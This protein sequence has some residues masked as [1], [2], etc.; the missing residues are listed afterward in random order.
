VTAALAAAPLDVARARRL[1]AQLRQQ[2]AGALQLLHQVHDGRAWAVLGYDSWDAYCDAELPELAQLR[3]PIAD[4]RDAV[5]ALRG[6]GMSVRA[7]AKP[8]GLSVGTVHADLKAA[9]VQLATVTSLDGRLR[10]GKAAAAEPAPVVTGAQRTVDLVAAAGERG[11]TVREL[12]RKTGWHH[13]QASGQLSRLAARRRVRAVA[14]FRDGCAA[15][16][17]S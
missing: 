14:V 3:L 12:C 9:D 2:L 11:L 13:G 5:A 17:L 6:R 8:L 4:R 7:I 16:R 1:T 10:P 15:Y